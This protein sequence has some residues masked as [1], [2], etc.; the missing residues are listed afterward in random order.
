MGAITASKGL[1][2]YEIFD[3][4]IDR[5]NLL[6]FIMK[7]LIRTGENAVIIMDNAGIN[8]EKTEKIIT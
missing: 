3:K 2:Y 8:T 1:I 5:F 7:V 4:N 6:T